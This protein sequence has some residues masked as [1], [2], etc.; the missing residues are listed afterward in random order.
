MLKTRFTILAAIIF[1]LS[2]AA[3]QTA[4]A[5]EQQQTNLLQNP[6]FE[7]PYQGDGVAEGWVAWHRESE[8]PGAC[9]GPYAFRPMWSRET[10]G[11]L[12]QDGFVSQHIGNQF[13]TWAGGVWQTVNVT[14]GSTYRF[15]F[16]SI[17]RAS[18]EQY[19]AP[20]D[21]DVNLGVRAGIDPNGS[22][23]WSDSDVVWGGAGSPHDLGN[24]ANWQQFA[25]EATAQSDQVTVFVSADLRGANQC[26]AHLDVWFDGAQLVEVGPPPTDTP[27]PQ[28]TQPP[29]PTLPPVT[30]TPPPPTP[31]ATSEAPPTETPEPTATATD[32]PEPRGVICVNAFADENANGQH[33]EG[34]GAM[35]GVSFTLAQD[36]QVV[37]TG[38]STGP[39]PICFDDLEPGVYQ[40]AQSVPATL[41]MTTG[42]SA[43]VTVSE[44]QTLEVKFGSRQRQAVEDD[45]DEVASS[46]TV[47]SD[48]EEVVTV[49]DAE[50]AAPRSSLLAMSG[51]A[52]L[53]IA[54]VLLGV[55][56]FMLLRQRA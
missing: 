56:I 35:A 43:E 9:S 2:L 34:E 28:P 49:D 12:V 14:P 21:A 37:A 42:A 31:T 18:N 45:A 47:D 6:S 46:D 10:N 41:E 48:A 27:P 7:D 36:E 8:D 26:R 38:V 50:P 55:L 17:G 30:N 39:S 24:Q 5:R 25:V 32:T 11:S 29:Q 15:S 3:S 52:V 33:D 16:W 54:V 44:G 51:L 1:L 19:P 23:L 22:G 53:L 13:D 40:V 20:S 4:T